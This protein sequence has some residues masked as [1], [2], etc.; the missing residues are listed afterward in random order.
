LIELA[1][2][3]REG[4]RVEITIPEEQWNGPVYSHSHSRSRSLQ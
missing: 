3:N 1:N 4:T 2:E